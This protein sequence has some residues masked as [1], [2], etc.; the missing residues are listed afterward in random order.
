MRILILASAIALTA[1]TPLKVQMMSRSAG[2]VHTGSLAPSGGGGGTMTVDLAGKTCTGPAQRVGSND[3]FGISTLYGAS[4]GRTF[5]GTGTTFVEGDT[6]V[7]ALLQCQGG[8][9]LRCDL[10]GRSGGGGGVCADN[11]NQVYD[12]L[13]AR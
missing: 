12:V 1:C 9:A 5:T 10:S 3:Q 8:G 6:F 7:K 2:M 11:N 13:F 4:G